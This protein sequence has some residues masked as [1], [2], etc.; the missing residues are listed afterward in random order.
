MMRPRLVPLLSFALSVGLLWLILPALEPVD[1]LTPLPDSRWQALLN[2]NHNAYHAW[3]E[4]NIARLAGRALATLAAP[5]VLLLQCVIG[6]IGTLLVLRQTSAAL[7]RLPALLWPASAASLLSIFAAVGSDRFVVG[8]LAWAPLLS[9]MIFALLNATRD[10]Q[11]ARVLPLWIVALFVSVQCATSAAQASLPVAVGAIIFARLALEKRAGLRPLSAWQALLVAAIP[12]LPAVWATAATPLAPLPD[13]PPL[14]HV[15]PDTG[16]SLPILSITGPHYRLLTIDRGSASAAYGPSCLVLLAC[17]GLLALTVRRAGRSHEKPL[18]TA[19]TVGAVLIS[20]DSFLPRDWA[21]Q[22]PI[23]SLSRILPW[24]GSVSFTSLA[25]GAVAWLTTV[26]A[27]SSWRLLPLAA[28][29]LAA[30]V[31]GSPALRNPEL[32]EILRD[33][34]PELRHVLLSPS[35]AV[36]KRMLSID[37]LFLSRIGTYRALS[38]HRMHDVARLNGS[39]TLEPSTHEPPSPQSSRGRLRTYEGGQRGGELLT[40]SLPSEMAVSGIEISPGPFVGDFPRGLEVSAG[41]CGDGAR[42]PVVS[43]PQWQGALLFTQKGLPY[44]S[45]FEDVRILFP[46]PEQAQCI[47]VRQ[48]GTTAYD[49]SVERVKVLKGTP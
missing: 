1:G 40:V 30:F 17:A 21:L 9:M 47:F 6:M 23:A 33:A 16:E 24:G 22:A 37:P 12:L 5:P 31:L 20:L 10:G 11:A 46:A 28:A 15:V 27:C 38:K 14:A 49:W 8:A 42:H 26:A 41:A 3:R 25:V 29:P 7:G 18:I 2:L 13:Y 48:T 4:D 45:E 43:I 35:A 19:A 44:W 34:A 32:G 36:A 39:F